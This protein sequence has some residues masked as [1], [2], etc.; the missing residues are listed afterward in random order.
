MKEG[1]RV[2][3][4]TQRQMEAMKKAESKP[5]VDVWGYNGVEY[6]VKDLKNLE[7]YI[8]ELGISEKRQKEILERGESTDEYKYLRMIEI[9]KDIRDGKKIDDLN[10]PNSKFSLAST[11]ER[12]KDGD[13]EM[14]GAWDK[15]N[16]FIGFSVGKKSEVE[17]NILTGSLAGGTMLHNHPRQ[18][19]DSLLGYSFSRGDIETFRDFAL[20]LSVVTAIEGKYYMENTQGKSLK[21]L[22][23]KVIESFWARFDIRRSLSK[24]IYEKNKDKLTIDDYNR[25]IWRDLHRFNQDIAKVA[26][27]SY[28]FVPNKGYESLTDSKITGKLPPIP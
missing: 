12:W 8:K 23:N 1:R 22:S 15:N 14:G 7:K 25:M 10:D 19:D 16:R 21:K 9:L 2:I 18:D 5:M 17:Y 4:P 11:A 20:R 28:K 6:T 27:Y 13:V 3:I 24:I 26:G